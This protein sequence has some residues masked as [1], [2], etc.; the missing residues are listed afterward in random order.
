MKKMI[1]GYQQETEFVN[2]G[3]G[4]ATWCV[5]TKDGKKY[6]IKSFLEVTLVDEETAAKLPVPMVEAKRKSCVQFRLRKERLYRKLKEIQN[7]IFIS[8]IELIV[9]NGHFCAVTDYLES[10]SDSDLIH[11]FTPRRKVILMRTLLLAMRDLSSNHIVHSDIKPDNIVITNNRKKIPQLKIIDFDSG[12]FEDAPPRTP[13]EYHGD[14]VYLAPESMVF[15]QA[16]GESDI[17][18]TC[19]VDKFAVGLLL[20]KMWCGMLP[21]YDKDECVNVAEALLLNK[22]VTLHGSLPA[23]LTATI[24]G[25]LREDPAARISYDQAYQMLGEFLKELA[26][27]P[28][29]VPEREAEPSSKS[30]PAKQAEV[31]VMYVDTTG[32]VLEKKIL[33]IASNSSL[34]VVP[35]K[36]DGY[37]CL[38]ERRLVH[39]DAAGHADPRIVT[40]KYKKKHKHWM[41]LLACLGT[42]MLWWITTAAGAAVA[43]EYG[44]WDVAN[45]CRSLCPFYDSVF[46][47]EAS[48]IH[49]HFGVRLYRSGEYSKAQRE[50]SQSYYYRNNDYR[51]LCSA[52]LLGVGGYYDSLVRLIGLEDA[53]DLILSTEAT[54]EKFMCGTWSV[55]KGN[56]TYKDFSMY[57]E[58]GDWWLSNLPDR[59]G[60]GYW[61][62]TPGYLQ[63]K[64]ES[65]SSGYYNLH[66][67]ELISQDVVTF[68]NCKT[69][70]KY[71][72]T[73]K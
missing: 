1:K 39:V 42:V 5:A 19:A 24:N 4:T 54:F 28:E 50:F 26:P 52:H 38:D 68:T 17:R 30:V 44:E 40:F 25:F 23:K 72:L 31:Q 22:P 48:S 36:V 11:K 58:N 61:D 49:F 37:K 41:W 6:F 16:E 55:L 45:A 67:I 8:P 47:S 66:Q 20:H 73:R 7:G 71:T 12:F 64:L 9:H 60:D 70:A 46:T 59:P 56:N 63:F 51:T 35:G 3:A 18:L 13:N 34:N 14:I 62:Y 15:M 43:M 57:Q 65:S 2:A 10:F 29:A 33:K 21:T 32:R 53:G 69:N 27:D